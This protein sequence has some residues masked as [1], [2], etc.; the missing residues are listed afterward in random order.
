MTVE[1]TVLTF[2]DGAYEGFDRACDTLLLLRRQA[3]EHRQ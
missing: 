1:I 3:R 2:G